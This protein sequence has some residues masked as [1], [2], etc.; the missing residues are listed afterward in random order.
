MLR[1]VLANLLSNAWK[2]SGKQPQARIEFGGT[3]QHGTV[4]WFVRD[5]GAGFDMAYANNLFRMFQRL[6]SA[7]EFEGTGIGLAMVARIIQGHGG[8]VW[9][10]R[11]VGKGATFYF[12][13]P[14][15]ETVVSKVA[16]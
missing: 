1:Q 12:T 13:L 7:E 8:E 6:H 15:G 9:A 14:L 16:A 2:Y 5:N 10:E 4:A 11:V 3:E